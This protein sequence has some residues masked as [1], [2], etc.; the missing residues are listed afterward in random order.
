MHA[1]FKEPAKSSGFLHQASAWLC[2]LI[3]SELYCFEH[4]ARGYPDKDVRAVPI[5]AMVTHMSY[6]ATVP[7]LISSLSS[8]VLHHPLD[9][10]ASSMAKWTSY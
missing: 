3:I 7:D 4:G 2:Y 9:S 8:S 10:C 5:G 1:Q 6:L